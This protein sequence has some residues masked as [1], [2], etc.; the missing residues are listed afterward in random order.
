[1]K[2][3]LTVT[4]LVLLSC[5]CLPA[6]SAQETT[7]YSRIPTSK[8]Q[9]D[10]SILLSPGPNNPKQDDNLFVNYDTNGNQME[11]LIED[12]DTGETWEETFDPRYEQVRLP[13]LPNSGGYKISISTNTGYFH[14]YYVK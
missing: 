3:K 1:M 8:H 2:H 7:K 13:L 14:S 11:I 9:R 4:A 10:N 5:F 12:L 6:A